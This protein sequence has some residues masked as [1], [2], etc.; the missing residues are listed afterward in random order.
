MIALGTLLSMPTFADDTPVTLETLQGQ[1][2]TLSTTMNAM[3][4]QL[5]NL[6]L[7]SPTNAIQRHYRKTVRGRQEQSRKGGRADRASSHAP[8]CPAQVSLISV[9]LAPQEVA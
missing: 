2:A 4:Q 8:T 7:G 6:R 9:R 1:I 3:K 5:D